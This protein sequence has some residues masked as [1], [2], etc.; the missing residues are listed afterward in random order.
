MIFTMMST[1]LFS[2]TLGSGIFFQAIARDNF[3]NPAKD[4]KI[5]IQSSIIQTTATG[6]VV[7]MEQHQA[8]TDLTGVF[9]ISIGQGI[10]TG[11]TAANLTSIDW[12]KGPYY[13]NLKVAITPVAP[14]AGWDYTKD[15]VDLGTTSFGAVPYALYA[16]SAG[17]VDQKVN[18]SDTAKMLIPYAK[19]NTVTTLGTNLA[20]KLTASDTATMLTNYAKTNIVNSLA[21]AAATKLNAIDTASLSSRIN[22]KANLADVNTSLAT[23]ANTTDVTTSLALKA[24]LADVN[25]SLATKAN[26]TDVTTSLALK[27]N[28]AD[29]N[30]SLATKANTTDVTTSLAL[31][32]NLT[33]VNTSLATKANTTDVT[34]SLALKANLTSPI[35]VTPALG[36]P[37]SGIATNLTGL[38]LTTGVTGILSVANGGTG[39]ASTGIS[40]QVLTSVGAGNLSWTTLN[41]IANGNTL[42]DMLYWNGSAWVNVAAGSNGQTL[43]FNNGV[44]TWGTLAG[45]IVGIIGAGEILSPVTGRIWMDRNLGATRVA[46]SPNDNLA[47]GNLYQ[48]GR[49]SDGHELITWS[50]ASAGTASNTVT[51]TKSSSDQPGDALFI[52]SNDNNWQSTPNNNLWNGDGG[53]NNNPCPTGY[54]VPTDAEWIA[55]GIQNLSGAFTSLKLTTAGLRYWI[56]GSVTSSSY[57]GNYWSKTVSSSGYALSLQVSNSSY[58]GAYITSFPLAAGLSIRCIKNQ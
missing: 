49:G 36:T 7:L 28:L 45:A 23:K 13:L 9:S 21:L 44:P 40:G 57:S 43:F 39:L 38:P 54:S 14:I 19:N 58:S 37:S 51:S 2:Q 22:L 42:G 20:T 18:F 25:T 32:A 50:S 46:V 3:A 26:T 17:G 55:E 33:D 6:T 47:Y 34:T 4:R 48:W 5:Y 16:A 1:P 10:K 31:K 15:W 29:V 27:A 24:N 12:S 35:L 8:T 56:N 41:S 30:T 53:V 11:G 52:T